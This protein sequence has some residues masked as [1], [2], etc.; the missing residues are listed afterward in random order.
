MG[1]GTFTGA[2]TGNLSIT[3]GTL[4]ANVEG[5]LT[6]NVTGTV[7]S[8][9]NHSTSN[10]SEGSNLYFTN[11]R[12]QDA[13]GGMFTG[14]TE[15]GIT[16]TYNDGDSTV[17]FSVGTLNQ[18]TTGNAAT[19]TTLQTARNISGVSFNGS[20]DITLN[21]SAITENSNLY[22]TDVEQELHIHMLLVQVHTIVQL[23]Q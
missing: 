18:S 1:T 4:V 11:E 8:L 19:A 3:T 9:S 21:T 15:S 22:Y 23:V 6:G 20:A 16:V 2:T 5:N 7:S 13:V 17:D 10:V 12:A 14:N